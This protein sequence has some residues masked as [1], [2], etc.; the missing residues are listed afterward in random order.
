MKSIFTILYVCTYYIYVH[1]LSILISKKL[2]FITPTITNKYVLY[3]NKNISLN[4]DS[5]YFTI[6][7]QMIYHFSI[8]I[9]TFLKTHTFKLLLFL[10]IIYILYKNGGH[11][12]L[13]N[14]CVQIK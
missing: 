5:Y 10:K 14:T 4:F 13:Y 7:I 8:T 3:Y 11:I 9:F 2:C 12:E 6:L 1:K